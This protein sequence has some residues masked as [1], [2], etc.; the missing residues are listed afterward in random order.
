MTEP[1]D[2]EL[3]KLFTEETGSMLMTSPQQSLTS[4]A[5]PVPRQRAWG[6][7]AILSELFREAL[8]WGMAYGPEI[9]AQQWDQMRESM[10]NQYVSRANLQ[11]GR[12]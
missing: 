2:D 9:P 7:D 8:A 1:T 6:R 4:P 5:Q 3:A 11:K 10:V 12:Q